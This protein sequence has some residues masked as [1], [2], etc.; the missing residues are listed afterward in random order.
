M[1]EGRRCRHV[2]FAVSSPPGKEN[3]QKSETDHIHRPTMKGSPTHRPPIHHTIR[4]QEEREKRTC[5]PNLPRPCDR[6]KLVPCPLPAI[7]PLPCL[8][9]TF[10]LAF[11]SSKGHSP[12]TGCSALGKTLGADDAVGSQRSLSS[13]VAVGSGWH[14]PFQCHLTPKVVPAGTVVTMSDMC[15]TRRQV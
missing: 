5:F 10:R 2:C 13:H 14:G 9:A 8:P 11:R 3:G 4:S 6:R 1:R 12:T 7:T 15:A